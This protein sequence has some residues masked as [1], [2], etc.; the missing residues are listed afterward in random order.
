LA[1]LSV[2]PCEVVIDGDEPGGEDLA[3]ARSG[4][5]AEHGGLLELDVASAAASILAAQGVLAVSLGRKRGLGLVGV[6]TSVIAGALVFLS[7]RLPIAT[8]GATPPMDPELKA[9]GPPF[10]TRDG[11]WVE[12]EVLRY[13]EW[14]RAWAALGV[15]DEPLEPAW[16][17][18]ALRYLTGRCALHAALHAATRRHTVA[19]LRALVE[20]LGVAVARIRTPDEVDA[21]RYPEQP[22]T[23]LRTGLGPGLRPASGDAPLSGLCVVEV[24]TRLQGPLAGLLLRELGAR[25]VKVEPPGGDMG[26]AGPS[27]FGRAAYLAYN[28]G[29]DVVELDLKTAGGRHELH[30][31]AANAD[32]FLHNSRPGRAERSRYGADELTRANPGLVYAHAS[33]WGAAA[34][35][36]SE[37][38][39]DYIVQAHAGLGASLRPAGEPPFPSR[40]TLVDVTGG[41]LA[42]EAILAG[43]LRRAED[44]T[45]RVVGTSLL[46]A[47]LELRRHTARARASRDLEKFSRLIDVP[48]DAHVAPLLERIDENAWAPAAPWRF[49]SA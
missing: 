45:G 30:E 32:V 33:G 7:H 49:V 18:Y 15:R 41:L 21:V 20:P 4:L 40:V 25:V 35:A 10:A 8:A 26:R 39:G 44:G 3:Q 12:L 48:S 5:A 28:R 1:L 38:A 2:E 43:L 11:A 42:C 47:A 29:K 13:D 37:I 16:S 6:E 24:A 19:E 17:A 14:C 22:W 9:P 36:P 31:L 46:A 27:P 34:D 23:F